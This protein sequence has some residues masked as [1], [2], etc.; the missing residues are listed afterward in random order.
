MILKEDQNEAMQG[1]KV[2]DGEV[3]AKL[4]SLSPARLFSLL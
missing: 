4:S 2:K 3:K 1:L